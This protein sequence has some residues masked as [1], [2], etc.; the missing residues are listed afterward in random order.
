MTAAVDG[1]VEDVAVGAPPADGAS[2]A[3]VANGWPVL[4]CKAD[5]A[6]HA[7]ANRC[8]HA[9]SALT[10]GRIRRGV[11]MCPLHGARFE[12]ATGRCVGGPY[13]PLRRFPVRER[14][15]ELVVTVPVAPPPPDQ[16]PVL[17]V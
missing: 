11:L 16:R 6:L 15:G 5:G 14:D 10:E 12:L 4:V 13:A 2:V 17:P 7:L 1:P 9:A 3:V 8:T